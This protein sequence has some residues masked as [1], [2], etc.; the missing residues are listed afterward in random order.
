MQLTDINEYLQVQ[1]EVNRNTF[2][3]NCTHVVISLSFVLLPNKS[4][5]STQP[6]DYNV[7]V[8]GTYLPIKNSFSYIV[9]VYIVAICPKTIHSPNTCPKSIWIHK[10]LPVFT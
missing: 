8:V 6:F 2:L 5:K 3:L 7:D 1:M 4:Y 9:F 10:Y